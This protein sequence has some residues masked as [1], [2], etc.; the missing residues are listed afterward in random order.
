MLLLWGSTKMK[1][2]TKRKNCLLY[3]E[4]ERGG[5]KWPTVGLGRDGSNLYRV[6][7][8]EEKKEETK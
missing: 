4:R 6:E 8:R 2:K 7:L 5:R 1:K 3:E